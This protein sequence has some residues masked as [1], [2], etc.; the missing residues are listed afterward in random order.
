MAKFYWQKE[1]GEIPLRGEFFQ[2]P[3]TIFPFFTSCETSSRSA[4][5]MILSKTEYFFKS[6][7]LFV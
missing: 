3:F 4:N 5:K 1:S 7:V 6:T 2:D